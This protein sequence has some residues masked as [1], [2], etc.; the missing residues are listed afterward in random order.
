MCHNNH[1]FDTHRPKQHGRFRLRLDQ[2]TRKV[3][4]RNARKEKALKM[5]PRPA[6]SL[7]P[8]VHCTTV[9]YNQRLREGRGFSIA[10][11]K[12]AGISPAYAQTIGISVDLRRKNRSEESV[13]RNVARLQDYMAKVV[14]KK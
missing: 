3:T 9:R 13:V 10:E 6:E 14:V 4:R 12:K 7:R 8:S 1:V 11:L 2:A 5:A